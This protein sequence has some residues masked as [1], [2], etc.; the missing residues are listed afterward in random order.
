MHIPIEP[1]GSIPRP[2][3]L[4]EASRDTMFARIRARVWGTALAERV[5]KGLDAHV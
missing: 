2:L 1:I 5:L 3:H 4:V